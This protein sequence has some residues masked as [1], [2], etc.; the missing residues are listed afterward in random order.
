MFSSSGKPDAGEYINLEASVGKLLIVRPLE[1]KTDFVTTFSPQGTDVVF[2]DIA[3]IDDV[4]QA[5]GQQGKV[6]R[7]QAILQ[8]YLKG[9]FKRKVGETIIGMLYKGVAKNGRPPFMWQDLFEDPVAV[10]RG[11]A[12]LQA[13]QSF[14]VQ[15]APSAPAPTTP[16]YTPP[17]LHSNAVGRPDPVPA[18]VAPAAAPAASVGM[19]T[20]DQLKQMSLGGDVNHHGQPQA[21]NAP[22]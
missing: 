12:W 19:T 13:N 9:T 11:T 5:T 7:S 2:A 6:W 1:Y 15:L 3:V 16:T 17:I 4:D 10:Q 18:Y 14:L 22:F 21:D 8:G 20:L